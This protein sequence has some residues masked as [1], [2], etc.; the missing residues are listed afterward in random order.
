MHLCR[1]LGLELKPLGAMETSLVEQIVFDQ[2]R[3]RRLD[4]AERALINRALNQRWEAALD[5]MPASMRDAWD[6]L[7]DEPAVKKILNAIMNPRLADVMG[8]TAETL[9]TI[10]DRQALAKP[11]KGTTKDITALDR[12]VALQKF[13]ETFDLNAS[14]VDALVPADGS[15]A[16]AQL[17]RQRRAI[18]RDI[19]NSYAALDSIQ[20]RRA[21]NLPVQDSE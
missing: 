21:H 6:Q 4:R 7:I 19:L 12:A 16:M 2:W 5:T 20:A 11:K 3:L 13:I 10:L 17:D 1:E 9:G 18:R 8:A 15:Q 14:L